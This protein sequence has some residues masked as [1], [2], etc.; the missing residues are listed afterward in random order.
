MLQAARTAGLNLHTYSVVED[1]EGFVGNFTVKVRKK[2]RYVNND[3]N[4][5][6]A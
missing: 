2:A 5:C 3:C 6:G 4:G 1:V